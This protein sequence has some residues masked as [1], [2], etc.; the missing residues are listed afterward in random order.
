MMS[1]RAESKVLPAN[2]VLCSSTRASN[3]CFCLCSSATCSFSSGKT[4]Q[5]HRGGKV[6]SKNFLPDQNL[7]QRRLDLPETHRVLA[8]EPGHLLADALVDVAFLLEQVLQLAALLLEVLHFQFQALHFAFRTFPLLP[9]VVLQYSASE[10][11][12]NVNTNA[13]SHIKTTKRKTKTGAARRRTEG[14][15]WWLSAGHRR[16]SPHLLVHKSSQ[17]FLE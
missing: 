13:Q 11:A 2:S 5:S 15:T 12:A 6:E 4:C 7:P 8:A 14:Q 3:S 16:I 1:L 17:N 9:L 10:S